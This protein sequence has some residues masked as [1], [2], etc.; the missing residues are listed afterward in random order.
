MRTARKVKE[1]RKRGGRKARPGKTSKSVFFLPV[2]FFI[3]LGGTGKLP[4]KSTH[5]DMAGSATGIGGK[6]IGPI[7]TGTAIFAGIEGLHGEFARM[8][9]GR[10]LA[11]FKCLIMTAGTIE[12]HVHM[13]LVLENDRFHRNIENDRL[14]LLHV[15]AMAGFTGLGTGG[16]KCGLA[17][18][19][20]AAVFAGLQ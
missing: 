14:W 18:M 3:S 1:I 16:V 8:L 15:T 11:H 4:I 17:I 13:T 5:A 2:L 20:G 9:L 19:A 10:T 12:P 6:G 7:V